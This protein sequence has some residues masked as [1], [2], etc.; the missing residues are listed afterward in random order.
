MYLLRRHDKKTGIRQTIR[1]DT[2]E[3]NLVHY[4]ATILTPYEKQKTT[5]M[6]QKG[7]LATNSYYSQKYY[8]SII[9]N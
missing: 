6:Q 1:K 5:E 4:I 7:Q 8:Y 9:E 3:N 2:I